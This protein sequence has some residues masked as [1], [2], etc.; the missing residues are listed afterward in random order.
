MCNYFSAFKVLHYIICVVNLWP[1]LKFFFLSFNVHCHLHMYVVELGWR[2]FSLMLS[3]PPHKQHHHTMPKS[4][5]G[6]SHNSTVCTCALIGREKITNSII[7]PRKDSTFVN[8]S[9]HY[10]EPCFTVKLLSQK[11]TNISQISANLSSCGNSAY[12]PP[13]WMPV[14]EAII[15]YIHYLPELAC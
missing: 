10:Y 9:E 11:I 7:K 2:Y 3:Q 14:Y 1:R 8:D 12:C 15:K 13:T 4:L 6:K 5:P